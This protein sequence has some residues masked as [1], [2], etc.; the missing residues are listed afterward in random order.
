IRTIRLEEPGDLRD[1]VWM[2]AYFTWANEGEAVGLIPTRYPGSESSPDPDIRRARRTEWIE[3][4][5]ETY[6]GLGQRMLFTDAG[7]YSLM[8]VRL[9]E[10]QTQDASAEGRADDAAPQAG[11]P[12]G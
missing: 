7:E 8:D 11:G 2:P 9:I 4:G 3:Q 10:L 1:L 5:A 12:V 6:S